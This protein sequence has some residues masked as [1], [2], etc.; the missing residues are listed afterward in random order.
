MTINMS[1]CSD[2]AITLAA[3]APFTGRTI[4]IT[5]ISHIRVQESDRIAAIVTELTRLGVNCTEEDDDIIIE[6]SCP[7]PAEVE[8]Y[9]DHRMAMGF[10]LIGIKVPGT[11][12][13]NP[14][15]CGK[16]FPDY[17]AYLS[18]ILM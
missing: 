8:T 7:H 1:S 3:I 17:F 10:S 2:Q 15:C 12:I 14:S 5:G 13:L 9:N 16:T 18:E 11:A 6:P 4:R